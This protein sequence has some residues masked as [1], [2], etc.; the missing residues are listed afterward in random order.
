M[1]SKIIPLI[2]KHTVYVEPFAGGAAIMFTKPEPAINDHN[3]YREVLNDIDGDLVN[4]YRQ[5]RDH[6]DD[7]V[8]LLNLTP[9]S[10]AE[11]ALS[12]RLN[13]GDDLEKAR[14]YFV[15][16]Q[17]GFLSQ[18][19]NGWKT[20]LNG[21]NDAST[22]R[23]K[24]VTLHKYLN[25][26]SK[27]YVS[28]KPYVACIKKWD[29]PQTFFYCDPPYPGTDQG[30]YHGYTVTD[31]KNLVD[32]LT[33]IQGSFILS[34]YACDETV[35]AEWERFSFGHWTSS[36]SAKNVQDRRT[37]I[38]YRH[39][40][41]KPVRPEIQKLYDQGKF[42]CFQGKKLVKRVPIRETIKREQIRCYHG[43]D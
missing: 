40:S 20:S 34:C 32:T 2:P 14:R 26:I 27:V 38:V 23:N 10:E 39:I 9:F 1:A 37:E 16:M 15:N 8:R 18:K 7:L 11:Y 24:V 19:N 33:D 4:F 36:T 5:L 12:K 29:S 42:D 35:P 31:F 21:G 41:N 43:Y 28:C 22:F 6:G 13:E 30:H 3:Y 25:R 17:Q